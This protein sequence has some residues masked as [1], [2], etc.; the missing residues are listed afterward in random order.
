MRKMDRNIL[1][2]NI[3][4]MYKYVDKRWVYIEKYIFFSFCFYNANE[5]FSYISEQKY[6]FF[7]LW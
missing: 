1:H 6:E 4:K 2:K 3:L 5:S 7:L